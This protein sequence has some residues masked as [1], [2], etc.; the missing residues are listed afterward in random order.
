MK[1]LLNWL[2]ERPIIN[3]F[4]AIAYY[5]LVVL[6]HEAAGR[7]IARNLDDT[8]GRTAYN[9]LMLSLALLGLLAYAVILIKNVR[10]NKG[11]AG[12]VYGTFVVTLALAALSFPLLIVIHVEVVHFV[13]YGVMALLLFPLVRRY[14]ETA[15]WC[16]LLGAAD[17][18]WQHFYLA[19]EKSMYFDFNDLIINLLGCGFGL[20]AI[21]ASRPGFVLP[22]RT[23][24]WR[25]PF[26]LVLAVLAVMVGIAFML[27]LLHYLPLD[28][29]AKRWAII[30]A[31]Q[32]GFWTTVH[33]NVTFHVVQPLEGMVILAM[34]LLFYAG[35]DREISIFQKWWAAGAQRT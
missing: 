28:E 21:K 34:L 12:P 19:P 26:L 10:K 20:A 13:Q 29:T 5:L 30:R 3:L 14:G 1:T 9:N 22:P 24:A 16:M 25:S 15:C 8:L 18:A 6:P 27:G 11:T 23:P 7:I 4:I 35:L 2:H 17:E 33:P 31:E 32:P